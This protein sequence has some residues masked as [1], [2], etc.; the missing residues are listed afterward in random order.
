[1]IRTP[2]LFVLAAALACGPSANPSAP[3]ASS[4]SA[5]LTTTNGENL[6]GENLNGENLNGENLN[7]LGYHLASVGYAAVQPGVGVF[8]S[9]SIQGSQLVGQHGSTTRSGTQMTGSFFRGTSDTGQSVYLQI[10][11]VSQDPAPD[12][13]TWNYGVLFWDPQAQAWKPL[14]VDASG[15]AIP[16]LAIDGTWSLAQGVAGGGAKTRDGKNFTFACKTVGAIGK[17][18]AVV[19]YKPWR[20]FAGISLDR[21]HQACVRLLRADFCGDGTPHTQNG[22]RV[23]LYDGIGIQSDTEMWFPEAEWD[24]GGARCFDPLNRS[25][26]YVSCYG[27]LATVGCGDKSHF[28]SGT[29]LIDETPTLG[30]TK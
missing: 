14:C 11:S 2:L 29:L 20:T 1:M 16:A 17:C 3:E 10:A 4:S 23:N 19:G 15:A 30:L 22:N 18:A 28:Q 26:A 27:V 24:E 8:D 5:A 12:D 21:H 25:R 9:V 7:G 13:D 6:N